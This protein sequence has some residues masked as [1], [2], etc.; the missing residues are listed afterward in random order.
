[1]AT[2]LPACLPANL[3]LASP[4]NLPAQPSHRPATCVACRSSGLAFR[5]TSSLRLRSIFRLNLPA[6][7]Q[8]APSF[9]LPVPP[10]NLTSDSHRPLNPFGAAFQLTC[11]LRRRSTF[12]PC[13]TDQRSD[14]GYRISGSASRLNLRLA[15]S[16]GLSA[17]PSNSTSVSSAAAPR[18][19]CRP[20]NLRL[21]PPIHRPTLPDGP[22]TDSS[23]LHLW[24]RFRPILDSRLRS[25]FGYLQA[26]LQLALATDPPAEPSCRSPACAFDQPSGCLPI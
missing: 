26:N 24:R 15:S 1:M 2:N 9:N 4:A 14:T 8:L 7:F 6:D 25:T 17:W 23:A 20:A 18:R 11:G 10:S 3:R 22:T 13:L 16:T 12:Q 5:L 19:R 21:S